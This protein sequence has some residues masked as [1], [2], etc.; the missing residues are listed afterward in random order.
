MKTA[1]EFTDLLMNEIRGDLQEKDYGTLYSYFRV[2]FQ[3]AIGQSSIEWQDGPPTEE[4]KWLCEWGD[5]NRKYC[6]MAAVV[7]G[8]P[9]FVDQ[10]EI[11]R[12]IAIPE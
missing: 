12:H 6:D 8:K 9:P 2:L 3:E 4:G 1:K 11:L 5:K 10:N 7:K